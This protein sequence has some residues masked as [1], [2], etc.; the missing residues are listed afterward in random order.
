MTEKQQSFITRL[1]NELQE[2]NCEFEIKIDYLN[3]K[4]YDSISNYEA[5]RYIKYLLRIKEKQCADIEF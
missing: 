3:T 5:S 1:V 4:D 2:K